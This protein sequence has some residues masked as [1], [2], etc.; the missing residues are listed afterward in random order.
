MAALV[1]ATG[2]SDAPGSVS[3]GYSWVPPGLSRKKVLI[4]DHIGWQELFTSYFLL[5][6]Q[7]WCK[8]WEL[9]EKWVFFDC[10]TAK[11][12]ASLKPEM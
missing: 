7:F 9:G 3:H 4:H 11:E 10:W 2:R 12:Y 8:Y 1:G 6:L 5:S